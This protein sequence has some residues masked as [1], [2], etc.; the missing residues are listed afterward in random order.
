LPLF[1]CEI[2]PW[3]PFEQF[4]RTAAKIAETKGF[5]DCVKILSP[6]TTPGGID[7]IIQHVNYV[8]SRV[9]LHFIYCL[10]FSL[11]RFLS[12]MQ[13]MDVL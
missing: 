8:N 13:M 11:F 1:I 6:L 5:K 2:Y 7:V 9:N 12:S 3:Y 4:G 10:T